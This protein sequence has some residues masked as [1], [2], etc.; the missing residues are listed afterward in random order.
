ML[1]LSTL[2]RSIPATDSPQALRRLLRQPSR[3][4]MASCSLLRGKLVHICMYVCIYESFMSSMSFRQVM[5]QSECCLLFPAAPNFL[6]VLKSCRAALSKWFAT[7][8]AS[9]PN[10]PRAYPDTKPGTRPT[11]EATPPATESKHAAA[12]RRTAPP[13]RPGVSSCRRPCPCQSPWWQIS[14]RI[15]LS[16]AEC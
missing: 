1:A 2:Y 11:T 7:N 13:S 6:F 8:A 14:F 15:E 16:W 10:I 4:S 12:P 5:S 3:I 9:G